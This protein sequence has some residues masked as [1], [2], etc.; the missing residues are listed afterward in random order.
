MEASQPIR[1]SFCGKS[2]SDTL[3]IIVGPTNCF[4]CSEC[5]DLCRDILDEEPL[6]G[7]RDMRRGIRSPRTPLRILD[8]ATATHAHDNRL[9]GRCGQMSAPDML[10]FAANTATPAESGTVSHAITREE[11]QGTPRPICLA[12]AQELLLKSLEKRQCSL[13]HQ[14]RLVSEF[15]D[16]ELRVCTRCAQ[17][18]VWLLEHRDSEPDV[19]MAMRTLLEGGMHALFDHVVRVAKYGKLHRLQFEGTALHALRRV[20]LI[21]RDEFHVPEAAAGFI[22]DSCHTD[23]VWLRVESIRVPEA[24]I[25]FTTPVL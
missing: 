18:A 24:N 7:A 23:G 12:C 17:T 1:C 22:A 11:I 14:S 13:C 20:G 6:E 4:I 21:P 25:E 10:A 19:L 3:K 5:V 16:P 8:R 2:Q 9:C 15:P